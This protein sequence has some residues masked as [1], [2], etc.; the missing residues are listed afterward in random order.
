MTDPEVTGQHPAA[1]SAPPWVPAAAQHPVSAFNAVI[2]PAPATVA[3][4]SRRR[5]VLLTLVAVVA[6]LG[7]AASLVARA[8]WVPELL[9]PLSRPLGV[10]R[11]AQLEPFILMA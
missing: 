6:V 10:D 7:L 11:V 4:R 9:V 1:T 3:P 2:A 5:W 8:P